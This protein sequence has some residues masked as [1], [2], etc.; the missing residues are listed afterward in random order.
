[1]HCSRTSVNQP[2]GSGSRRISQ[3]TL[4]AA[5]NDCTRSQVSAGEKKCAGMCVFVRC[6]QAYWTVAAGT[7]RVSF[8]F[9]NFSRVFFEVFCFVYLIK[10]RLTFSAFL[11]GSRGDLRTIFKTR[12]RES[13]VS[14]VCF[15]R[16]SLFTLSALSLNEKVHAGNILRVG[17]FSEVRRGC[18]TQAYYYYS[19]F[20]S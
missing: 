13:C 7:I 3:M 17:V 19:C 6:E 16:F 1:M 10:C 11:W 12:V 15:V 18:P 8:F 5:E 4:I 9:F 14:R 2:S 20:S